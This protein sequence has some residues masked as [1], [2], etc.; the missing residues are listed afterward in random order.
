MLGDIERG[1]NERE[2]GTDFPCIHCWKKV[3]SF[4][5]DISKRLL[6]VKKG[7]RGRMWKS[8][9]ILSEMAELSPRDSTL[10]LFS[11]SEE[12]QEVT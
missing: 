9:Q 11:S 8:F 12:D 10:S 3:L 5:A 1:I 6:K 2:F 7:G 4:G